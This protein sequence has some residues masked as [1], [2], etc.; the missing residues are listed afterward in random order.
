MDELQ[1]L[2]DD[3]VRAARGDAPDLTAFLRASHAFHRHLIALADCPQLSES[4]ERLGIPAFWTRT[5][6]ERRWWKKWDLVH[7][8]DLVNAYRADDVGEAERLV[9]QHRDWVKGLARGLI[10]EAGGEV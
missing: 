6:V 2:A 7:H 4:Y 8:T 3:F 10:T 5:L 1:E 9:H